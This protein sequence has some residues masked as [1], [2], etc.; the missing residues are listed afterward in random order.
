MRAGKDWYSSAPAL[1]LALLCACSGAVESSPGHP[2]DGAESSST[3][4][5]FS[6]GGPLAG[7]DA[8]LV[9]GHTG[10]RRLTNYEYDNTVRDLLGTKLQPARSFVAEEADG[11]DNVASALGMT[12]SQFEAYLN[13]AEALSRELVADPARTKALIDCTP[14]GDDGGPCLSRWLDDFATRA[15]RRVPTAEEKKS[16]SA[17]YA[18]A[19]ALGEDELGSLGHVLTSLLAGPGFLYRTEL[20]VGG[21]AQ[22]RALDGYELASRL[23]YFL[24]STLPDRELFALAQDGSLVR[25]DVLRAQLTRMLA[26]PRSSAL[27]DNFAAQWLG[28][29]KLAQHKVLP[30]AY[31]QFDE[32]LR[33]S[34]LAEA[35][36]YVSEFI[37]GER[38]LREFLR[39][40]L[41]F[42]DGKL[43]A[44]YGVAA[45]SAMTRMEAPLGDRRG[46]LGLAAFLTVSS[47]AQRTSP[48]LRAKWILEELMCSTVP[49]PPPTAVATL[50]EST[51]NAASIDNV[52]ARLEQHRKDPSCAGCHARLDP[53]GLGLETF[54]GI[55]AARTK[56]PNGDTIDSHGE[57]PGGVVFDGPAALS[58]VLANDPRFRAC[59]SRKLLTYALGRSMN[60]EADL[61][62]ALEE[63]AQGAGTFRALIEAVVMSEAFRAQRGE[64]P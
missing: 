40:N 48:T 18:R 15:Y 3:D 44:L 59:V 30:D 8:A 51:N 6:S 32:A 49:P 45:P 55:G 4:D 11:F 54:D 53:I 19:R 46:Y 57:L 25:S 14:S 52:R 42:V 37:F 38:P 10:P 64:G 12:P 2:R 29:H 36:A 62:D 61:V 63:R 41:H 58:D 31:P 5:P 50:E 20:S 60:E 9:L 21:G 27:L 23:S 1:G 33:S 24:W 56:Y 13:A 17:A 16:L 7:G 28:W 43:A 47:F 35:R 34:M 39:A 26:D 22:T